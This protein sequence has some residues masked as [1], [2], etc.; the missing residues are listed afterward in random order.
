MSQDVRDR[1]DIRYAVEAG[2]SLELD[3]EIMYVRASFS[4]TL[5]VYSGPPT[6]DAIAAEINARGIYD[7]DIDEIVGIANVD[8]G[9]AAEI[10][11]SRGVRGDDIKQ[12][13]IADVLL[14]DD[15]VAQSI[16]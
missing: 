10:I 5:G 3:Q 4:I 13:Q 6:R 8:K 11:T 15:V 16:R 14:D 1:I 7:H 12:M 2:F 9:E